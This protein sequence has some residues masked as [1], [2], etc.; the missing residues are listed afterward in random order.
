M[1]DTKSG[2]VIAVEPVK[3]ACAM[4][5]YFCKSFRWKANINYFGHGG[6]TTIPR[7]V[8]GSCIVS[9]SGSNPKKFM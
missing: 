9:S 3:V 5:K 4:N 6:R 7:C 1:G 8:L 2:I